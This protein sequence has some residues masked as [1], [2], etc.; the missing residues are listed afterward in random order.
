[1]IKKGTRI[2]IEG[3][4]YQVTFSIESNP[5]VHVLTI[6][7]DTSTGTDIRISM[8]KFIEKLNENEPLDKM[9]ASK[10]IIEWFID[11]KIKQGLNLNQI[12][13]I[14]NSP[15]A[16]EG[17]IRRLMKNGSGI[18]EI[19]EVLAFSITDKFWSG[20][21]NTSINTIAIPRQDGINLYEKIKSKMI[22]ERHSSITEFHQSTD[23]EMEGVMV[24]EQ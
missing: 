20:I 2:I 22:A 8:T 15:A 11:E 21:L 12:I 17:Q 9:K 24:V 16:A 1:V 7:H 19:L 10:L 14:K 5:G 23:E 6:V 18:D 13:R 4:P 3:V